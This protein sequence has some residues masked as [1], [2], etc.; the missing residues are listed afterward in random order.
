MVPAKY[1]AKYN[2]F[3]TIQTAE[4]GTIT[5]TASGLEKQQL[6]D[7]CAQ[8]GPQVIG[9]P[10]F[11]QLA[12][13]TYFRL[14]LVV[15]NVFREQVYERDPVQGQT[16]AEFIRACRDASQGILEALAEL[17]TDIWL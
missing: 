8:A 3:V 11:Q 7:W 16:Q 14:S 2:V 10:L 15:S 6:I 12:Y 5:A 13:C 1:P 4:G 17:P 9:S